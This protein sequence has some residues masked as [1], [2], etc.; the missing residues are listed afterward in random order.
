MFSLSSYLALYCWT[1]S[2][3]IYYNLSDAR[4]NGLVR[5][6]SQF[7]VEEYCID[8]GEDTTLGNGHCQQLVNSL[9]VLMASW[10]WHS[11]ILFFFVSQDN[12]ILNQSSYATLLITFMWWNCIWFEN[13]CIHFIA[14]YCIV[15]WPIKANKCTRYSRLFPGNSRTVHSEWIILM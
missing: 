10:R 1:R 6:Q 11:L 7:F 4:Y 15:W 9:T 13:N 3:R 2:I 5:C 12:N 14:S 8:V